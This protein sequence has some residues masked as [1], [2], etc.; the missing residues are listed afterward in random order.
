[1]KIEIRAKM[2]LRHFMLLNLPLI[3]YFLT[4]RIQSLVPNLF[5]LLLFDQPIIICGV[6]PQLLLGKC[7]NRFQK[8]QSSIVAL[9]SRLMRAHT[10]FVDVQHLAHQVEI[11]STA[12]VTAA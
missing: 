10:H 6:R 4:A 1:M 2:E 5:S 9:Y 7:R 3:V 8:S 12:T 11:E